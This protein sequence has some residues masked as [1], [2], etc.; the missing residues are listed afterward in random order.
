MSIHESPLP[1]RPRLLLHT[2]L[3]PAM[4]ERLQLQFELLDAAA[5]D[6]F[7]SSSLSGQVRAM[8]CNAQSVIGSEQLLQ[9][10]ALEL[11]VV[12]GVGMDGIDLDAAEQMGIKVR[13]T[14]AISAEDIAD[15]ALA[16]LLA[17]TREIV[18]AH[19]F[20]RHGR[21]LRGRYPPTLR[22]SG[23][24]MGIVGLGRIGRAVA[25]RSQAFD[26]SIAYTGRAPKNDVPYRWCDSVLE[27]A[28]EVDFLVV[29]ASGGPATRG[30]IDA[31]VLQALGPQG[32]LVNVGRGSI[33]DEQALRQA[34][35]ER[36]IAAA[37]L[38]VFA[39]EP[40]VP[41]ALIDL[42]NTVLTPHM[43]SST[44]QGLQAML[45]QAEACLLQHFGL[46]EITD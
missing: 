31:R 38:D 42:P 46:P 17:A 16:L 43:A 13:N 30:L 23:Q 28:A 32:V 7:R 8:L 1:Q 45:A 10:P 19:E 29:C 21:W 24:R 44:R 4:R 11:I 34:L 40:Q 22:F 3:T 12:I 36:T 26:L 5:L 6:S 14:P 39:H 15:H 27:L 20:V 35:Q 2:A 33:V 25:R 41:E 9:W 37:A 18:Q